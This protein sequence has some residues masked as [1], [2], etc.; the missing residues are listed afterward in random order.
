MY[1]VR[2]TRKA[3]KGYDSLFPVDYRKKVNELLIVLETNIRP[4]KLYDMIQLAGNTYRVRL[5]RI[6]VQYNIFEE[7]KVVLVYKIG[8]RDDSTYK[9]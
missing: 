3:Q 7:D 2:L 5:G 6:R 4:A 8:L 9:P 1:V